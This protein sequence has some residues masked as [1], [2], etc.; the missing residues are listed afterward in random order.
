MRD[1]GL[2]T[3]VVRMPG[4]EN[5]RGASAQA[6]RAVAAFAM[7]VACCGCGM[8]QK[9]ERAQCSDLYRSA[10]RHM[11]AGNIDAAILFLRRETEVNPSA[12]RAHLDLA[13]LLDEQRIDDREAIVHYRAYLAGRPDTQKK[14]MIDG[15]IRHL[16]KRMRSEASGGAI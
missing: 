9:D 13:L 12:V 8:S 6:C 3:K 15:R 14:E 10:L 1:A 16:E 4:L 2:Q 11:E 5:M 7:V